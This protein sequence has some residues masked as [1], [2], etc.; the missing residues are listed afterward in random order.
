[1][2]N[3]AADTEQLYVEVPPSL[4]ALIDDADRT[5]KDIVI[6]GVEKELGVSSE[7]SVA[8]IDRKIKRL[9]TQLEEEK[10][11]LERRR[12]RL[13]DIRGDLDRFR[14]IRDEQATSREDY[15]AALDEVLDELEADELGT[16]F[17]SHGRLDDLREEFDRPN[18]E[19]HLDLKERAAQQN[20]GLTV[21]RFKQQ[22]HATDAD[23]RALISEQ[24]GGSDE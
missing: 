21:A 18:D 24:W 15:N 16:I 14:T 13:N 6:A 17:P 19:V 8:V 22:Y 1:M 4:K 23:R 5:N 20:R 12:G 2:V 9:E 10:A 3:Q 11:E 7:D